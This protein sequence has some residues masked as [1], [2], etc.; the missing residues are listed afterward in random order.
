MLTMCERTHEHIGERYCAQGE[1]LSQNTWPGSPSYFIS[2]CSHLVPGSCQPTMH[3]HWWGRHEKKRT[4]C[5]GNR[6]PV[7]VLQQHGT[8]QPPETHAFLHFSS[9]GKGAK[10]GDALWVSPLEAPEAGTSHVSDVH[11][12]CPYCMAPA[13]TRS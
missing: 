4:F 10:P 12:L 3:C 1:T 13:G 8:T 7:L 6:K 5:A 9:L 2:P 11:L